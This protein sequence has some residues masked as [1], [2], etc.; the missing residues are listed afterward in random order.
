MILEKIR[1]ETTSKGDLLESVLFDALKD[2]GFQNVRKQL[3][4]SQY[5][6][7]VY[8]EKMSNTDTWEFWKFE[9]KNQQ[10]P[11]TIGDIAQKLIWHTNGSHRVDKF[12]VVTTSQVS[13]D[14]FHL[15]ENH[16]FPFDIEIW[17]DEFLES[18]F[19]QS[20]TALGRF[21]F[22]TNS[23]VGK[24]NPLAFK[25]KPIA[26]F[27]RY[28][29]YPPYSFD[30]FI[31][32]GQVQKAFTEEKFVLNTVI[33]NQTSHTLFLDSIS[34]KTLRYVKLTG[35]VL[36]QFK[37]K[38]RFTVEKLRFVPKPNSEGELELLNEGEGWKVEALTEE[39]IKIELG[40][41]VNSG[42][43]EIVIQ[44]KGQFGDNQFQ[45]KSPSIPL[46]VHGSLTDLLPL[47]I[48][49]RYYDSP[50]EAVLTMGD[51]TWRK[52]KQRAKKEG[53]MA[54]L[55]Q[56]DVELLN[57]IPPDTTWKIKSVKMKKT[58][59]KNKF[60]MKPSMMS[61]VLK[62]LN[63]PIEEDLYS[64]RD[65]FEEVI[66]SPESLKQ[67]LFNIKKIAGLNSKNNS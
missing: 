35:R 24:S 14:V 59:E 25:R 55:G 10:A 26:L 34:V 44:I 45:L 3:K 12:V 21:N 66:S 46:H 5:G 19:L 58:R 52:I 64:V 49:G 7:D 6:F 67:A 56:T 57:Q 9:C 50:V 27:V 62:D 22:L 60:D 17:S 41:K 31:L 32:E 1:S 33:S 30:Y 16:Q 42:F 61:K 20:P 2:N 65:A 63:L 11:I 8:A 36:R 4:G 37:Q 13:N 54:Y 40:E 38:G 28:A 47:C 39:F 23:N 48:T 51:E 53:T 29:H 18:F 15:F 43:Y